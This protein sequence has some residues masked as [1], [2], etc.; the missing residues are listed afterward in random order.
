MREDVAFGDCS[1]WHYR[2]A[3]EDPRAC[4]VMAHGFA[5][6]RT[7]GLEGFADGFCAAGFDVLLFDYR[8]F[9]TSGGEPRQTIDLRGQRDD[10]RAAVAHARGL[11]GVDRVVL[12]GVSLAGGHV[13]EVAASDPQIAA[14]IALT[15]ATDGLAALRFAIEQSGLK[16]A[17][18]LTAAAVR[19]GKVAV[20][21]PPGSLA[22]MTTPGSYE[23]YLEVAGPD[24][25][26]EVDARVI[27]R[28]G[29]DRPIRQ[30]GKLKMPVLVQVAD[31]DTVAPPAAAMAAAWAA[32]ALVRHYP[33]DHFDVYPGR[34]Y[35]DS[36]LAHAVDFLTRTL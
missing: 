3:G 35:F 23:A 25:V 18:A 36:A 13:F 9:G 14:V 33:C 20:T 29:L 2:A 28:L 11:P 22:V 30:A 26:N 27:L 4:V 19:G 8:G 5:G 21:G 1:A 6:T 15:P 32:R 10:Y 31:E 16:A 12:W 7:C 17:N 24:W 34:R